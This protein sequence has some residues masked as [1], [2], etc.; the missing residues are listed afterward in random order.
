MLKKEDIKQ[1]ITAIAGRNPEI[2]YALNEMF[3]MGKILPAST[4]GGLSGDEDFHFI[5]DDRPA[6]VKRVL[7]FNQGTVP[8]E[9]RL[10]IK[11]GEMLMQQQLSRSGG[12]KNFREAAEATR[13]AGLRLLVNEEI[14]L[15]LKRLESMAGTRGVDA[16]WAQ[17]RRALLES[18]RQEQ[19]PSSNSTAAGPKPAAAAPLY[20]G[21]VDDGRPAGFV[22][23]PYCMDALMQAADINLEFFNIR[24]VLG[25]WINGVE[26]NLFACRVDGKIEGIVYLTF[27]KSF[28]YSSV[29]IHYIATARGRPP[30][31]STPER[32]E[33]KGVGTFLTAGVWMLWKNRLPG[34]KDLLLDSEIGARGFYEGIGFESR[35]IMGFIMREPRGRLV[36]A[37]LE[38]AAHCPDLPQR[39]TRQLAAMLKKQLRIL[40][41]PNTAKYVQER[42]IALKCVR[43]CFH[44]EMDGTLTRM[45]RDY[46]ERYRRDV[47][48]A[49]E[50]I[51]QCGFNLSHKN[52]ESQGS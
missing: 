27:K 16:R 22:Q 35:G 29:E 37:I 45:A 34:V 33:L 51:E 18:I 40:R 8:I 21:T 11:Y 3:G 42:K 9:E 50:M 20:R 13:A 38:M 32:R 2:G 39:T 14:E 5:F 25:C 10:L 31:E 7:Y 4:A 6:T 49:D 52:T 23:F 44:K 41:K 17:E 30:T 19:A 47:P 1:A 36:R 26:Q 12:R 24:F 15:A 46:L 43:T 28:F 48:E